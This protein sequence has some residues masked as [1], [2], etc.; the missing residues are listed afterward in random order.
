MEFLDILMS[1]YYDTLRPPLVMVWHKANMH[2]SN[3]LRQV[4]INCITIIIGLVT[5]RSRFQKSLFVQI[6]KKISQLI[7]NKRVFAA[8]IS[9]CIH[10]KVWDENTYI[11]P[12][13]DAP[14]DGIHKLNCAEKSSKHLE[15]PLDGK[16]KVP[17][18]VYAQTHLKSL[19]LTKNL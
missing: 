5:Q 6:F 2:A 14:L 16:K 3:W 19:H 15:G 11:L 18:I 10:Y 13:F 12:N 4:P 17:D 7:H 8:W 9:N 1:F